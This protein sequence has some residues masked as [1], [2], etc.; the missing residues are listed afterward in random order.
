MAEHPPSTVSLR[1]GAVVVSF[2]TPTA[3]APNTSRTRDGDTAKTTGKT[4]GKTAG[5]MTGKTPL[6]VPRLLADDPNLPV[7]ELANH[8]AIHT[9]RELG[10]PLRRRFEFAIVPACSLTGEFQTAPGPARRLAATGRPGYSSH[11]G[12]SPSR[13]GP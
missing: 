8:R 10:R 7:S 5:R 13:G 4:T 11:D 2:G 12:A 9:L 1:P 6:A 3:S